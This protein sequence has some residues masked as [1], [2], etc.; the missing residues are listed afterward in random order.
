[1]GQDRAEAG[2]AWKRRSRRWALL[3][4]AS[5]VMFAV[6]VGLLLMDELRRAPR[7]TV[8]IGKARVEVALANTALRQWWGL[9]GRAS[10]PDGEGMLF[11]CDPPVPR[12][13]AR[14]SVAFPLDVVFVR[15]DRTVAAIVPLDPDHGTAA[16]PGPVAWVLEVPQGWC[17]RN[18]VRVGDTLKQEVPPRS[19]RGRF[20]TL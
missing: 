16:S 13:F 11:P 5:L 1:M 4:V 10:L 17:A 20:G 18:G 19:R 2:G 15:A 3:A 9:Q 14:R 8:T 7:A 6:V 12:T